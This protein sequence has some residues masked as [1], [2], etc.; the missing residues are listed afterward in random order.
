M[1]SYGFK[2]TKADHPGDLHIHVYYNYKG[3]PYGKLLGRFRIPSLEP[4][5]GT[6]HYL[7]ESEIKALKGWL[8]DERQ[9]KKLQDCLESTMFNSHELAKEFIENIAH[10]KIIKEN[11]ETYI[12]IK[13]SVTGRL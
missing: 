13:I 9:L 3:N 10:G 11:G 2:I 8:S 12:V 7:N 6:E 1:P 4:L 5:P